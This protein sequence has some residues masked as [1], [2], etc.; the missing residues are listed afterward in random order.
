LVVSKL[1]S[2]NLSKVPIPNAVWMAKCGIVIY[3]YV[4]FTFYTYL[5]WDLH[6]ILKDHIEPHVWFW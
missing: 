5:K 6:N 1:P 3:D 2:W 4:A